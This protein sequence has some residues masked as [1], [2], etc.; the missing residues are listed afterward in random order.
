MVTNVQ[1]GC[2]RTNL[3][4]VCAIHASRGI[5]SAQLQ[6][7]CTLRAAHSRGPRPT[8]FFSRVTYFTSLFAHRIAGCNSDRVP[9]YL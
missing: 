8:L 2:K 7:P 1:M 4:F 5:A 6:L 9:G 3:S